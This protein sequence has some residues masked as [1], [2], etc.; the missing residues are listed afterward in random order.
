MDCSMISTIVGSV[1]SIITSLGTL[2]GVVMANNKNNALMGYK[3]DQLEKKVTQ[4]NNLIDRMYKV[5][6]RLDVLEE[7]E[8]S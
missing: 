2:L 6:A 5:E 4:H 7:I 8:H 1:V 3:I